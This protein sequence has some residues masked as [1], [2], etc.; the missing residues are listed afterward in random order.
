MARH[1]V[2]QLTG[3]NCPAAVADVTA[4]NLAGRPFHLDPDRRTGKRRLLRFEG[5][6]PGP[7]FIE[8]AIRQ[9]VHGAI[10]L[11]PA[12][13]LDALPPGEV[14]IINRAGTLT[15]AVLWTGR[16]AG[17]PPRTATRLPDGISLSGHPRPIPVAELGRYLLTVDPAVER[18][19]LVG[20]L[21]EQLNLAALH[22]KLGLLTADQTVTSPWLTAF[23]H[24]ESMPWR[25]KRVR[26]WLAAHDA[27]IVEVKTRG[28]AVDPEAAQKQLRGP[29]NTPYT[30]FVLRFDRKRTAFITRRC[31]DPP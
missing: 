31:T 27:G 16:L 22:P 7:A 4:A 26:Q 10:K 8:H 1:N 24:L 13:P 14:E 25:P 2:R 17:E 20:L 23:E 6:Q 21:C 28:K 30:V 12:V 15:Q 11:S 9:G 18:A 5:Y 3:R 29:G 19:G